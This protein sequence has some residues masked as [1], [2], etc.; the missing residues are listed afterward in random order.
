MAGEPSPRST[1]CFSKKL[2]TGQRTRISAS[3]KSASFLIATSNGRSR[4][5]SSA[6]GTQA[7]DTTSPSPGAPKTCTV[8]KNKQ[9]KPRGAKQNKAIDSNVHNW[10]VAKTS[11]MVRPFALAFGGS[12]EDTLTIIRELSLQR[13]IET[14]V[15]APRDIGLTGRSDITPT[16]RALIRE[17]RDRSPNSE[18]VQRMLNSKCRPLAPLSR[19]TDHKYQ[20][21]RSIDGERRLLEFSGSRQVR[22]QVGQ[23][24]RAAYPR[25]GKRFVG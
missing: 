19:T 13:P 17:V 5:T 15:R 2:A 23:E 25:V 6:A 10:I 7:S 8:V 21:V 12:R 24:H 1:V 9:A 20:S 11:R 3:G 22:N 18:W 4:P 14:A 16:P